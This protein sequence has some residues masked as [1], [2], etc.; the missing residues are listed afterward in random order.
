MKYLVPIV[1]CLL[2]LS[3]TVGTIDKPL[4]AQ[5]PALSA[6]QIVFV[7]AGDLWSVPRAGGDARR[8]TTGVGV[9][10]S[11]SFSPDGKWIAFTGQYDGNTDV[12]VVA[13]EG[14][15]PKRLTWHPDPDVALGWSPDG[16]KVLFTLVAQQLLA[17]PRALPRLA[18]RRARREAAAADGAR[19]QPLARRP[20]HR[21]RSAAARLRGV[22]AL[23]RRPDDADLD[24]DAVEQPH[25][26]SAARELERLLADVGRRQGLLPE[27]SQRT[28]DAVLVRHEDEEGHAG[29]AQ[30]RHGLQ[31]RLGRP[32]RHRHRAVRPDSAVRP[33]VGDAVA[34]E[35]HAGR[36]HRR[37]A[38][39]VSSTSRAV[40]P[41][42]TSRRPARA[43]L[44]EARGDILTVPAEKGDPRNLTE[45]TGVMERDPAWSPD[46][47]W[48]AYFSDESGEYELHV[49]D[50][51]GVEPAREDPA[52][53]QADV[54]HDA[55][56]VARQQEDRLRRCAPERRGTSTSSRRSRSASTRIGSGG[57]PASA[58]RR[59]RPDSKWLA[60]GK[61]LENYLGAIFVYSLAD[62]KSTQLTDGLSDARYPV[63]DKDGKYLYFTASTDSGPSL[64]ADIRS[65]QPARCR[66]ACTSWSS[67]RPNRRRSRPR[68]TRRSRPSASPGR[69]EARDA[70]RGE[71]RG[72]SR[73][74][75]RR[76]ARSPTCRIDWDKINQRILAMPLPAR[77]YV[78]LQAGKRRHAVR[79]RS[80][81][82]PAPRP[83]RAGLRGLTVHRYDLG[84]AARTS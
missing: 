11:P 49:R 84:S 45:T 53:R 43:P 25:R 80:A 1:I 3:Q 41:T 19:R 70:R 22:E 18:R 54:L 73:S 2:G 59:G 75:S 79:D 16:R 60:Y 6:T 32:R 12:F 29:G 35:D 33:E 20:A 39:E 5:Q 27:R 83:G 63:F 48:I 51:L 24:R 17:H 31:V 74:P 56:L 68:A 21:L 8:L 36:R 64:E 71:A 7:F 57:R 28:G 30:H 77:R 52:R 62:A 4:L 26:E 9:E 15:V 23:S 61:R 72:A 81:R 47:K 46:G 38:P 67:R 55:A 82:R 13:A 10:S 42:R 65:A 37:A 78:Q 69:R 14:G 76:A 34:G 40:S 66:A 44:F 50:S 58:R